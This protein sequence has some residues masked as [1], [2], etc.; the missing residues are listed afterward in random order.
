[1]I[2]LQSVLYIWRKIQDKDKNLH[3]VN[4]HC[5]STSVYNLRYAIP[6]RIIVVIHHR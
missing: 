4:S 2:K 5:H 6:G 3:K 1:M